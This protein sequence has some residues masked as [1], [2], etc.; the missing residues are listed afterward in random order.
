MSL[1]KDLIATGN[2][3]WKM[4]VCGA[5]IDMITLR[6]HFKTILEKLPQVQKYPN[7][8]EFKFFNYEIILYNIQHYYYEASMI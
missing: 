1:L 5:T 2:L 4:I 3:G 7:F 8:F 6:N